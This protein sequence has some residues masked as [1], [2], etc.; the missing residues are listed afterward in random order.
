LSYHGIFIFAAFFF[1]AAWFYF[2]FWLR[3][4]GFGVLFFLFFLFW[5]VGA[6]FGVF[7]CFSLRASVLGC[8]LDIVFL[9]EHGGFI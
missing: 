7:L 1:L 9:F 5:R 4:L 6:G 3:S 8:R 2:I